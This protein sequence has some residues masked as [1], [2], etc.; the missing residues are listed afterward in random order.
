MWQHLDVPPSTDPHPAGQRLDPTR[1]LAALPVRTERLT[2]RRFEAR[3]LEPQLALQSDPDV[4]R[5]LPYDVRSRD[6][7]EVGLRD[8]L[9]PLTLDADDLPLRLVIE[10]AADGV[11]VGELTL[12]LRSVADL[13]GEIGYVIAPA[14]QGN[15]FAV[16]ATRAGLGVAFGLIGLHRVIGRCDVLNPASAAVMRRA[17]MRLEAV[18]HHHDLF[19]GRWSDL[20]VFAAVQG[21]WRPGGPAGELPALADLARSGPVVYAVDPAR[22]AAFYRDVVGLAQVSDDPGFVLLQGEQ[23]AV[24][25]VRVPEQVARAYP[26]PVPVRRREDAAVKLGFVVADLDAARTV[27]ARRGGVLDPPEREWTFAG[28]RV[29]DGHDPEGNVVQLRTAR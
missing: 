26:V 17:G 15:G 25:V 13:Q 3:D 10:R 20:M 7:V 12:I 6:E 11:F 2:L 1:L 18:H 27:A 21:E 8:R 9:A 23:A 22:V 28:A 24:T 16:E 14:F 29:C 19:K 4:V 5:W